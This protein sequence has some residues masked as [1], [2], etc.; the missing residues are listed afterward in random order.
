MSGAGTGLP[1]IS[2]IMPTFGS[3]KSIE[4]SLRSI[5]AQ[6][7]PADLVE[8][9]VIDGGSTDR[10]TEI[11]ARW[12][13][14]VLSNPRTQQEYAKHLGL[15]EAKGD[16]AVFLDSDEAFQSRFALANRVR[17]FRELPGVRVVLSGGYVKPDGASSAND[18]I[19]IF[20]DPF[21]WFMYGTSSE[22]GA[23]IPSWDSRY[24][25]A[26]DP[27]LGAVYGFASGAGLP[28]VDFCAGNAL[29]LAWLR[30]ELP[31]ELQD[32][33]CIPRLFY[34]LVARAP[35]VVVLKD[36]PILHRSSDSY[37]KLVRK[38]RW[39]VVVNIHYP[40]LPGTGFSNR[41]EFQARADR[42]R[43]YLFIPYALTL[44]G[45]VWDSV[46]QLARTR[47]LAVLAHP[48]LSLLTAAMILYY[49]GLRVIGLR[50]KLRSYGD[51]T[52]ELSV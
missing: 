1:R 27:P 20:S 21:A 52:R 25:R 43:K 48:P 17:A 5:R 41:E 12:G 7:Y 30:L 2:V 4:E 36:D 10:T 19:N 38:L 24:P 47:K 23:K 32:E 18:Y 14:R 11:A 9:L 46:A 45:P 49:Y 15:L 16:V 22:S 35:S 31:G 34:L 28:L 6:E 37:L 29:D 50:P 44:L 33:R 39:R 26:G 51:E 8:I 13:A 40:R 3:E 42:F